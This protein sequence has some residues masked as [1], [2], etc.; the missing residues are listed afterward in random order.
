MAERVDTV[1]GRTKLKSRRE[2][3]WAR[4]EQ[5]SFIGFRKL[6]EGDGTW[7]ARWRSAEG[8]QHY[9]A[10]GHH[11]DFDMAVKAARQW[12]AQCDG[13]TPKM[14]TV[15]EACRQYV[16]DRRAREGDA[17]A[18]DAEGRFKLKFLAAQNV[19]IV[20]GCG[21]RQTGRVGV[22]STK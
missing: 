19:I 9:K 15:A 2:P 18:N 17:N 13:A 16:A 6:S 4:I 7:I 3:Y 12:F 22:L 10:L 1:T 21:V 5:G 11:P 20:S 8:K 14:V